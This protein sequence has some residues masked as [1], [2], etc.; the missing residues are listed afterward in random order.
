MLE[1]Y[2]MSTKEFTT[3]RLKII[4]CKRYLHTEYFSCIIPNTTVNMQT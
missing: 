1:V 3:M 4:A 2:L